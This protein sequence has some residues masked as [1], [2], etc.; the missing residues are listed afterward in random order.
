MVTR[1]HLEMLEQ[2][3]F[4]AD[5][6]GFEDY[7]RELNT[8]YDEGEQLVENNEWDALIELL[9]V[10]KPNSTLLKENY[11]KDVTE[12]VGLL[13]K[14]PMR[15]I[16][17]IMDYSELGSFIDACQRCGD[18]VS[19]NC[20]LKLNG[21]GIRLYYEYGKFKYARTRGRTGKGRDITRNIRV[22]GIP[23]E[24]Y[25][26]ENIE[27]VEVRCEALIRVD[28]YNE[29][30]SDRYK[31]PLACVTHLVADS[32]P[33]DELKYL[34][35]CAYKL[36]GVD[37][38][39]ALSDEMRMLEEVGFETPLFIVGAV[40]TANVIPT[41]DYV[42][43]KFTDLESK[44]ACEYDTDGIVVAIDDRE[45][46]YS[47]P[48]DGK[49]STGNVAIKMGSRWATNFFESVI[50]EI[51]WTPNKEFYTP[52][53]LIEPVQMP[54]GAEVRVVPLYNVGVMEQYGLCSGSSIYFRFGG[55]SG[56][57]CCDKY[58]NSVTSKA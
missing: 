40:D 25:Q 45:L 46:F 14:Y 55:E 16:R 7:I 21:H 1:E 58:G 8:A 23:E 6:D 50:E 44:G 34:K 17:T 32:T 41:I 15:S 26:W 31:H 11:G 30:F 33:D 42:L 56:V 54:N 10:V 35:F 57:T 48:L 20:S 3:G 49:S 5:I 36:L 38:L 51:V 9:R 53:A 13:D 52:K 28:D 12:E 2:L 18:N 19:L 43:T 24:V 27:K 47:C 4:G 37:G 39:K 22:A 29:Y